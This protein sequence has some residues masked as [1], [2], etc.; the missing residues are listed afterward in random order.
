MGPSFDADDEPSYRGHD[1]VGWVKSIAI[2]V[3]LTLLVL[4][5]L[6]FGAR[7]I[8]VFEKG[9]SWREMDWNSDGVTSISEFFESSDIGKREVVVNGHNCIDYFAYK[10]GL[11]VRL[12]CQ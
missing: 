12:D 11:T 7:S 1:V 3:P 2:V 5:V 6:Y 4:I 9:F 10:D 8:A